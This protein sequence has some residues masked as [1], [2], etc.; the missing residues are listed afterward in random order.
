[1]N[2][3]NYSQKI[4]DHFTH[5]HNVGEIKNADGVGEVGNPACG[6]MMKL[7]IKVGQNDKK[8]EI[9]EDIKFK[10]Y[11]CAAAI[12]TSSMIT[13]MAMGK[14]LDEA[15][16][17][18]RQDVAEELGGLSAIKMH[19]SNLAADALQAAIKDYNSKK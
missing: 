9:I 19:C 5:P 6:D 1:M 12:A 2:Q 15:N 11:G 18:S 14:T 4:I 17:I 10:T 13:D 16:K 3:N 7:T 8:Q